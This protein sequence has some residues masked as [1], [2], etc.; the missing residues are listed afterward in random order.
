[1]TRIYGIADPSEIANPEYL[2]GLQIAVSAA[3]DY[4]LTVVERGENRAPPLPI[5]LLTQARMAMRA[6]VGLDTVFRRYFAG[7]TLLNEVMIKE[8]EEH[9]Q[10]QAALTHLLPAQAVVFDRLIAAISEEYNRERETRLNSSR[11]R[12][13]QHVQRLLD[14][15]WIDT[16]ELAYDLDAHHLGLIAKGPGAEQAIRDIASA[17]DQRLLL[18]RHEE[19]VIWAWL[20]ARRA[21]DPLELQRVAATAWPRHASLAI[22]EPGE[23]LPG[24]RLTH[25]Q[26]S[27]ALSIALRGTDRV[28]RYADI[29]L[30]SSILRDDVFSH[31]LRELYLAPLADERDGG[32]ILRNTLRAYFVADRN[33][34]ST[35]MALGISRR[36][37]T[38]RL[39]TVETRLGRPLG[40]C[41]AEMEAALR[42]QSLDTARNGSAKAAHSNG[43]G[44]S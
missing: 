21:A 20:G 28:V 7:Y 36:T 15:E 37:V 43:N 2:D 4:G 42:L 34:S 39:R 33:V 12:R 1:M 35:A 32:V 6:G 29:A 3:L 30:L 31:S 22:G 8:L 19:E 44:H 11:E 16:T 23:D 41:A 18:I 27:A 14:G 24:W 9:G 13:A 5:A 38:N 26:A 17:L 40:I 10:L 25:R